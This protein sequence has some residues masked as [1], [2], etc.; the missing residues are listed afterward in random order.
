M[1]VD[2]NWRPPE[3]HPI[4]VDQAKALLAGDLGDVYRDILKASC[5][6]I[7]WFRNAAILHNGTLTLVR[8]PNRVLGIT[9]AHVV[10]AYENDNETAPVQLQL[11]NAL[12]HNLEVIAL[13]DRLDLATIAIDA[14]LLG[15]LGNDVTP[16]NTWPPRAP[17]EGRGIML[18]GYPRNERRDLGPLE[19][20]WRRA[21]A[22]ASSPSSFE[23][24]VISFSHH[25]VSH[26]NDRWSLIG[27]TVSPIL[28][29]SSV[30]S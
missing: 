5:V 30:G 22:V 26:S 7:Y 28:D 1:P 18:A 8:T 19:V 17:Q 16:L 9:A 13:S 11:M 29:S 20:D 3:G 24:S 10:R 21:L 27:C 2:D 12:V 25:G 14:G 23:I 6:P 15:E 4:T